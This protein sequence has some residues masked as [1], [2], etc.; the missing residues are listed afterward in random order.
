M[1]EV[2][3]TAVNVSELI[4]RAI[5]DRIKTRVLGYFKGTDLIREKI[6]PKRDVTIDIATE[7]L[8]ESVQRIVKTAF[9]NVIPKAP[10][11]TYQQVLYDK[12]PIWES[13]SLRR[14]ISPTEYVNIYLAEKIQ[15]GLKVSEPIKINYK[16]MGSKTMDKYTD[17]DIKKAL[18]ILN[19]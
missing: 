4:E 16:N 12:A 2:P 13:Y 5:G 3:K 15:V 17:R 8:N 18:A 1:L 14:Q 9:R 11:A 19:L 10:V 6:I 7:Q